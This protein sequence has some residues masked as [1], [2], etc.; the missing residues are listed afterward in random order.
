VSGAIKTGGPAFPE[1]RT[2]HNHAFPSSPITRYTPG[3]TLRDYFASSASANDV[4]RHLQDVPHVEKVVA[5]GAMRRVV[6]GLPDNAHELAKYRYADAM[7]KAREG[8]AA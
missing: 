4:E 6:R 1:A 3:M 5:D 2:E 7:L 8:G